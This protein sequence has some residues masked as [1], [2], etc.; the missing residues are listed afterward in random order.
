MAE[1]RDD[2]D[3]A[4]G[5]SDDDLLTRWKTGDQDAAQV[6]VDRYVHRLIALARTRLSTKLRRRVD[7]EDVVQSAYR[8]FF[9]HASDDRYVLERSGDLWRLLAAIVLNKLHGQVE[10]HSAKKR[11][12]RMEESQMQSDRTSSMI[13]PGQFV[14]QP[15]S[16][17]LLG[18]SEELQRTMSELPQTHQR[19]LEMRLQGFNVT[20]IAEDIGRSERTVRRALENV[21][22]L[23]AQRLLDQSPR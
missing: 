13:N 8:S 6:I 2:H 22:S 14:R 9:R 21:R 5:P 12:V 7:P 19:I 4:E 11:S 1:D 3:D 15:T 23:L 16:D 18:V 10:F 17:E 20:E